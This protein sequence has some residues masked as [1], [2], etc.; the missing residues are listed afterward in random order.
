MKG[1]TLSQD[2]SPV[3]GGEGA[4]AV[5]GWCEPPRRRQH[6]RGRSSRSLKVTM[7]SNEGAD[8]PL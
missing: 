3:N 6:D 8:P 5:R 4:T 7:G 2:Q 1:K